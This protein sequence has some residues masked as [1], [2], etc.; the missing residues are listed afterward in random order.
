MLVGVYNRVVPIKLLLINWLVVYIGN[1]TGCLIT[2]YF[3]GYLTDLFVTDGYRSYLHSVTLSK[4]EEH[5]QYQISLSN[6][7]IKSNT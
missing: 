6:Y 7:L 4:L 5:G 3:F 2:S 1:W